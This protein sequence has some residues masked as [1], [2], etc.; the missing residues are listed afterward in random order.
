MASV[1][2][3]IVAAIW[4]ESVIGLIVESIWSDLGVGYRADRACYLV[5]RVRILNVKAAQEVCM[6]RTEHYSALPRQIS[7]TIV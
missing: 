5:S 6:Q 3:L 4:P 2:G 7:T 1:M